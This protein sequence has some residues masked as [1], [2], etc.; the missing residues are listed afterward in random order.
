MVFDLGLHEDCSDLVK[1]GK[2]TQDE[3]KVRQVLFF[4]AFQLD[5]LWSLYFGRP[6]TISI[7]TVSAVSHVS[8]GAES[9]CTSA[10]T[11]GAWIKHC[12]IVAEV[13]NVL[14]N[15]GP[16]DCNALN[17]LS[18]LFTET[19]AS[20]DSLSPAIRCKDSQ[21]SE[22]DPSAYA[23]NMQY[24]GLQIV[25]HRIPALVRF[26]KRTPDVCNS[27]QNMLPGFTR[28]D[29]QTIKHDNAVR[30]AR[31]A[32]TYIQIYGIER[33]HSTM[34]DNIF[35]AALS[36]ISH[37]FV[38]QNQVTPETRDMQWLRI[39]SDAIQMAQKHYPV[40]VRML[41]TLSSTVENTSL[42]EMF[43]SHM[44]LNS[45]PEP[46]SLLQPFSPILDYNH[47]DDMF[48]SDFLLEPPMRTD[49]DDDNNFNNMVWNQ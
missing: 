42:S 25:L 37:I 12:T 35:V 7:S 30:I 2:L 26:R 6:S 40:V 23:L 41:R 39:L 49:R 48:M 22:L 9:D 31:L 18:Q 1:Q 24:C 8:W 16:L 45:Y 43:T 5:S 28:E 29:A 32:H 13:A 21:I 34:L 27:L 11:L 19:R 15:P 46:L 47:L 38:A 14:N 36:L 4:A 3:A 20:Y 33:V 10:P 17:R 44:G